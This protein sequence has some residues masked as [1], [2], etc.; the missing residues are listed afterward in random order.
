MKY[1]SILICL[2][3]ANL[4]ALGQDEDPTFGDDFSRWVDQDADQAS[5]EMIKSDFN[6]RIRNLYII[7]LDNARHAVDTL[8]VIFKAQVAALKE[9]S[10]KNHTSEKEYVN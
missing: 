10:E 2:S 7:A 9:A 5:R 1:V 3:L 4:M 6:L 8:D